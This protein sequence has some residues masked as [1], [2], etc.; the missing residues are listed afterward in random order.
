MTVDIVQFKAAL[1]FGKCVIKWRKK[2]NGN[3]RCESLAVG[4]G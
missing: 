1:W 2:I 3:L 4:K